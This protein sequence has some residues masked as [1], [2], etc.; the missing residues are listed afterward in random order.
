MTKPTT[1]ATMG[2]CALAALLA[3]AAVIC[4]LATPLIAA[5]GALAILGIDLHRSLTEQVKR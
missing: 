3:A 5:A 2:T 4:L 1:T